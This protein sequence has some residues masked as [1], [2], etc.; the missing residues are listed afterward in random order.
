VSQIH[1]VIHGRLGRDPELK[2]V[3]NDQ[4][5]KLNVAADHGFGEK[6]TT[7]WVSVDYWGRRAAG[8]A[9]H[10]KKG[11]EVVIRGEVYTREYEKDGQK[12]TS[13]ECRADAVDFAGGKKDSG[14]GGGG[15][16]Y[17]STGGGYGGGQS[18]S[19]GDDDIPFV[20]GAEP[21]DRE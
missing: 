14:G 8:L 1:A 20:R 5:L 4:V 17:G 19:K 10:L 6:K 16:D 18:G 2:T 9:P 11:S 3:G 21:W 15:S 12:R 13:L 7:T